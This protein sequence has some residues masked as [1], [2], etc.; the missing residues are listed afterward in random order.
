MK[1]SG[2]YEFNA[3]QEKVWETLTDPTSLAACIPGCE[4]LEEVGEDE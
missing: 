2:S 1:L 4:K 3:T